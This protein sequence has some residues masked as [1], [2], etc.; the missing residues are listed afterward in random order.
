MLPDRFCQLKAIRNKRFC[1]ANLFLTI[2][3]L[4]IQGKGDKSADDNV[5]NQVFSMVKWI[6][7]ENQKR[8]SDESVAAKCRSV[9]D[10]FCYVME[11]FKM[12]QDVIQHGVPP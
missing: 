11:P 7:P 2:L 5:S 10:V 12:Y 9:T 6:P 3:T 8:L 1:P 4:E